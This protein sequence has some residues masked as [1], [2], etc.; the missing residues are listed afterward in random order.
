MSSQAPRVLQIAHNHPKF[1]PGGTELMALALHREALAQGVDSWYLGALDA[2]QTAP[3]LG[4]QMIAL[5]PDHRESALFIH[6]FLRF[7]LEQPE[8]H[9]F[10]REFRDYL[11]GIRPDIV[12]IHHVL[13][14]GLEAIHV[15]KSALPAAKVILTAHDY[16][17]F[18]ANNGQLFKH[19]ER[20]RCDG[21]SLA[22][23]HRCFG[24][25]I[26]NEKLRLRAIDIDSTL[27]MI[28][29]MTAPSHFLKDKLDRFL[30]LPRPVEFVENGYLG[31]KRR[32]SGVD[33]ASGRDLTFG[34]FG[35][36]SAV[37]GLADLLDAAVLLFETGRRDFR[38]HVHG[39]QLFED[40]ALKQK[41]DDAQAV[42]GPI[43]EF[44]GGY[45]AEDVAG[46]YAKV[47]CVVFPSI[48]YENAPLVIYEALHHGRQVIAYP[49][50]GAPEI[51]ERYGVGI[52]ADE[53]EP[54][55]LAHA[56]ARVLDDRTQVSGVTNRAIP[57]RQ[58]LFDAYR[59]YYFEPKT[60]SRR[61]SKAS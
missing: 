26:S 59:P 61:R 22:D 18:C 35:N 27:G 5:S 28:D 16:Y 57:D 11:L 10:L 23:C 2:T 47:D 30:R 34:Y 19:A 54:S 20:E 51:L 29:V 52:L 31:D 53:S 36:I 7:N 49:H 39:A 25:K 50:G 13:H 41:M 48:W 21:P 12:H 58:A 55:A 9:G 44:F 60:A 56:M 46:L 40:L 37:K 43:I 6:Q 32:A 8:Y 14:F 17:L 42:L 45:R 1:H 38:I 24:G 33:E 3:N 15:I 4:T